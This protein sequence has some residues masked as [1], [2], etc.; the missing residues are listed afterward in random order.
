MPQIESKDIFEGNKTRLLKALAL[1]ILDEINTLR[2]AAGLPAYSVAQFKQ[3]LRD[4]YK[5]L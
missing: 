1:L 3:A 4:R 2:L 5:Q